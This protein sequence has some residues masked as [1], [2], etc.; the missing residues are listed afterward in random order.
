MA[1]LWGDR[2]KGKKPEEPVTTLAGE[3]LG[4]PA[5]DYRYTAKVVIEQEFGVMMNEEIK[6]AADELAAEQRRAIRDTVEEHKR[7][8]GEVL[9]EEK[10]GIRA[11]REEIRRSIIRL[12]MG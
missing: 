1:F 12:G 11:R 8:I 9:E 10:R 7:V 6:S 5:G 3:S 2:S 4:P